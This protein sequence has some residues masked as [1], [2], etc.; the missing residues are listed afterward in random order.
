MWKNV[1]RKS[2]ASSIF[3]ERWSTSAQSIA[4]SDFAANFLPLWPLFSSTANLL[5]EN[6][7]NA[8]TVC[9]YLPHSTIVIHLTEGLPPEPDFEDEDDFWRGQSS[10]KAVGE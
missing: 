7:S 2:S 5:T 1:C 4:H 3:P 9:T 8:H 6:Q 10:G